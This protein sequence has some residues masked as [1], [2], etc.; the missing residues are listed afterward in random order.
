MRRAT[1]IIAAA[2]VSLAACSEKPQ[3]NAQGVKYDAAPWSG[4]STGANSGTQ[5]T[6]G[7]A[8]TAPGW[9]VGDKNAWQQQLKVRTQ[10]GQNDYTRDN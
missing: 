8:F 10:N 2:V 6:A 9:K 5:A 7:T 3:T 1:L 4:T